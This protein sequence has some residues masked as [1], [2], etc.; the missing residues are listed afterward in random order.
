MAAGSSA[1]RR[2]VAGSATTS[3]S[4]SHRRRRDSRS[5]RLALA[6][7]RPR[8]GGP[9]GQLLSKRRVAPPREQPRRGGVL[10]SDN[11][12]LKKDAVGTLRPK[13]AKWGGRATD[14]SIILAG[15]LPEPTSQPDGEPG[16]LGQPAHLVGLAW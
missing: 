6:V 5:A 9:A 12:E 4:G 14:N 2:N 11:S 15:W 3:D 10:G 8:G 7:E 1:C 16:L 13:F